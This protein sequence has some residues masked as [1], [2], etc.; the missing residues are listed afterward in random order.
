MNVLSLHEKHQSS[1]NRRSVASQQVTRMFS[2]KNPNDCPKAHVCSPY[3]PPTLC[4][5]IT[6]VMSL[7]DVMI[8]CSPLLAGKTLHMCRRAILVCLFTCQYPHQLF[9]YSYTQFQACDTL[10]PRYFGAPLYWSLKFI[11]IT[12]KWQ[13][14]K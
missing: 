7:N 1:C 4:I 13:E 14:Y 3:I 11:K 9:F 12:H 2:S 6:F 5:S 10:P 8:V